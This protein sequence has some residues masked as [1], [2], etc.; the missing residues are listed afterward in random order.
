MEIIKNTIK[1]G[2]SAGVLLP[3]KW[4]NSRVKVILEPLNIEK[5][6]LDI[7]SEEGLL[8]NTLGIYLVGSYARREES[9]ESDVDILAITDNINKKI[10]KGKYEIMCISE[11]EIKT[12]LEKNILPLL[13]MLKE[14]KPIINKN[15]IRRYANS[16]FNKENLKFHI[17]TTKSA[18]KVVEKDI[19]I[20][21]ELKEKNT[22]DQIAYSLILRLRTLYLI[23]CIRKNKIWK[24][25]EFLE[26]IKRISGS[27]NAYEGY[28]RS[29]NCEKTKNKLPIEEAEKLMN[30]INDDIEKLEKWLKEK[31]D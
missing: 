29:K 15:L 11:K 7:L 9:I 6:I 20:A 31:K 21:K 18:M 19:E 17:E 4:L 12:Q 10:K 24:K 30:Y 1:V 28:L 16:R 13:A 23:R 14:A 8:E 3:K 27:L 26:L 25:K 22:S 5:D 2:N